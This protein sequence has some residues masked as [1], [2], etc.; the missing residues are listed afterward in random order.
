MSWLKGVKSDCLHRQT[1]AWLI[2]VLCTAILLGGPASAAMQIT[3]GKSH[4]YLFV[5]KQEIEVARSRVFT[6]RLSWAVA[7]YNRLKSKADIALSMSVPSS[8]P[9]SEDAVEKYGQAGVRLATMYLMTSD[10][11]YASKAKAILMGLTN[12]FS[13]SSSSV[14]YNYYLGFSRNIPMYAHMYDL[15]Y[16]YLS[17]AE[18][19]AVVSKLLRPA[20]YAVKGYSYDGK[21]NIRSWHNLAVGGIGFV[22]EDTA[23]VSHAV[24]NGAGF[25]YQVANCFGSDGVWH[26]ATM[27]YH[28]FALYPLALLAEA[29]EHSGSSESLYSYR[30]PNG[31]TLKMMFDAPIQLADAALWLPGNNDSSGDRGLAQQE[32]YELA[33]KRYAD[34]SYD[35]VLSKAPRPLS[36]YVLWEGYTLFG[37]PLAP[38]APDP[39][40]SLHKSVGWI[41]LRE[42]EAQ[43]FWGSQSIMV[44]LDYGPHGGA[45]GHADK[46]NLDICAFGSRLAVDRSVYSYSDARH[47]SW[48]RQTLAHNTVV[49]NKRSQPGAEAMFDSAGTS[50]VLE[51][52]D[53]S[54]GI[55]VVQASADSA[56]GLDYQRLIALPGGYVID[57]FRL[58]S[59]ASQ[60][61]DWVMRAPDSD[62]T[63]ETN[64][65]GFT[66]ASIGAA[67][68][69]Y[70]H[71]TNVKRVVSGGTWSVTWRGTAGL[72][73]TMVGRPNTEVFVGMSPGGPRGALVP[74][75]LARRVAVGTAFIAVEEPFA[76]NPL[77]QVLPLADTS[78][79]AGV[80]VIGPAFRDLFLAAHASS[81]AVKVT[82]PSDALEYIGIS[83]KYGFVRVS[84][85]TVSAWGQVTGF[86][87]KASGIGSV[88]LNGTPVP[89]T[90]SGGYVRFGQ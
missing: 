23:L 76:A 84:G 89:F 22:L 1:S 19:T 47:L 56:Y 50:G 64:L 8:Y 40:T 15:L 55:K 29:A 5:S 2:L 31:N 86:R 16:T 59:S 54:A 49:V 17:S 74:M 42:R 4:P 58:N 62:S 32:V 9:Y 12:G 57:I 25:R 30:A 83:G 70:Q 88:R 81:A 45:H 26:E 20:A 36:A 51:Y 18:R 33:N 69:G 78:S 6:Q 73:L 87:V 35:W 27:Q 68:E 65:S 66:A 77:L 67:S 60:T 46:L 10:A 21:S 43:D 61:Y 63:L 28:F 24:D 85:G 38:V 52:A 71:V 48:D 39:D 79:V 75:V 13:A 44:M 3:V 90:Q 82:N 7:A 11:R 34:P 72:R 37:E 41:T 14:S 53:L 80:I